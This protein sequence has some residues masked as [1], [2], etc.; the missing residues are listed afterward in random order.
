MEQLIK[1]LHDTSDPPS[2]S[3][4]REIERRIQSLQR[5]YSGW[6][7]GVDLLANESP[8]VRFYGALTLIIKINAD[9]FVAQS[10]IPVLS[11][12]N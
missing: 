9:W 3:D 4:V 6:S 10:M 1:Q 2:P 7:V 5:E 11:Q 8:L 12:T